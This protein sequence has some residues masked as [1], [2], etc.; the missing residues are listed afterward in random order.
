MPEDTCV[1]ND[2]AS[3][4]KAFLES[5]KADTG[6]DLGQWMQA[7]S[8][9]NLGHRNDT[10]DWLRHQ[11]FIFS[12]ASWLERIHHNGGKPIYLSELP[13]DQPSAPQA[14]RPALRLVASNPDVAPRPQRLHEPK[15]PAIVP[16]PAS[17]AAVKSQ[18]PAA[19]PMGL[20]P[21]PRVKPKPETDGIKDTIAKAKAFAPLAR[22][23]IDELLGAVPEISIVP[24]RNHLEFGAS[25]VFGALVLSPKGLRL[26]L[27]LGERAFSDTIV[28][29]RLPSV[30]IRLPVNLTHM[31]VLDD[32]RQLDPALMGLIQSANHRLNG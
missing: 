7:I 4:E 8:D 19:L 31:I 26:C 24:K 3:K 21:A 30:V 12:K 6:R 5:L 17:G 16:A 20:K 15:R 14:S 23:L 32:A 1:T 13:P 27:D 18:A 22:H 10:I 11:G 2:Y 28:K 25:E 9:Q 29:T